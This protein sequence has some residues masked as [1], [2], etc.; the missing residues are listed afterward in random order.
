MKGK[1]I[2]DWIYIS[3]QLLFFVMYLQNYSFLSWEISSGLK[4]L[5]QLIAGMGLLFSLLAILSMNTLVSP[6]PSPK[7]GMQLQTK[8]VYAFSRHPIYSGILIF[9]Y[10]WGIATASEYK[11]GIALAFSIFIYFKAKYEEQLLQ[12]KFTAYQSYK[13]KTGMFFP[14]VLK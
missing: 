8:G 7:A 13:K 11:I 5:F 1:S 9:F 12:K 6:F 4:I 3:I 2:K 10:F 14:K